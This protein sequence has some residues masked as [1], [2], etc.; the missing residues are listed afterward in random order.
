MLALAALA[1]TA[2]LLLAASLL[3]G[4]CATV[5]QQVVPFAA[6]LAAPGKAGAAVGTV[7]AGVLCGILFSRTLAGFVGAHAGWREM[8]WLGV[9]LALVASAL[10]ATCAIAPCGGTCFDI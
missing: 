4:A 3:L 1:P 9:P 2:G 10:M 8:F 6:I 7:M 5:A